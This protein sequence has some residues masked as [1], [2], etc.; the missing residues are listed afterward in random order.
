VSALTIILTLKDRSEYTRRWLRY[1]NDLECPYKIL[2]GDGGTDV[3][4]QAHLEAKNEY[5]NLDYEYC[6]FPPDASFADFYNKL[7]A[8]SGMV[9]TPYVLLADND[10]FYKISLFDSFMKFLD[11]RQEYVGIRGSV[12]NFWL[13]DK[14]NAVL[15]QPTGV[16]YCAI[17]MPAVG[18][19]QETFIERAETFLGGIEQFSYFMNWYCIF[20]SHALHTTLSTLRDHMPIDDFVYELMFSMLMLQQG[21]VRVESEES[22]YRQYGTSIGLATLQASGASTLERMFVNEGFR[23]I[24]DICKSTNAYSDEE[25]RVRLFK[26]FARMVANHCLAYYS[27]PGYIRT[28]KMALSRYPA[29]YVSSYKLYEWARTYFGPRKFRRLPEIEK[30]ILLG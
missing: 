2:V 8:L 28:L 22:Y 13:R 23:S 9:T 6:R 1:M 14:T 17:G 24:Y 21:R 10:D 11:A 26:A 16:S 30:Y 4:I 27:A 3:D 19:E 25:T 15:R 20:R 18:L 7:L 5:P 29:L 12:V